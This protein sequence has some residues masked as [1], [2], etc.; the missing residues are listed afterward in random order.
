MEFIRL[1]RFFGLLVAAIVAV[2]RLA[3]WATVR[4]ALARDLQNP[5]AS[6]SIR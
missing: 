2:S 6:R 4:P 3:I 5:S 1:F